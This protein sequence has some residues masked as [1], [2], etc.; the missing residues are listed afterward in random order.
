MTNN[1]VQGKHTNLGL[2]PR[3]PDHWRSLY[4]LG[5]PPNNP[6]V[7]FELN[8]SVTSVDQQRTSPD[9]CLTSPSPIL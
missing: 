4:S 8:D 2:N 1:Q 7:H 9:S 3:L 6:I 5:P